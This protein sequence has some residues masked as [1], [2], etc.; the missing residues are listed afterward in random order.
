M[1]Q[2]ANGR[3]NP[4]DLEVY[5]RPRDK[6][7]GS[8]SRKTP[9]NIWPFAHILMYMGLMVIFMCIHGKGI[10]HCVQQ[11]IGVFRDDLVNIKGT[12]IVHGVQRVCRGIWKSI[13]MWSTM[14]GKISYKIYDHG[15]S[16][17]SWNLLEF[18]FICVTE[19]GYVSRLVSRSQFSINIP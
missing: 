18:L 5:G 14:C 2:W 8:T 10:K 9:K 12:K 16:T 17:R 11:I 3:S 6:W 7:L 19:F 4:S 13:Y 15:E 1:L